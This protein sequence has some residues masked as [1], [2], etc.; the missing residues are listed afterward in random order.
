MIRVDSVVDL[1]PL[2]KLTTFVTRYPRYVNTITRSVANEQPTLLSELRVYPPVPAGSRYKRTFKLRDGYQVNFFTR[3]T[4]ILIETRNTSDRKR[5]LYVKG[6]RQTQKHR[7]TGWQK[8]DAII[9]TWLVRFRRRLLVGLNTGRRAL[10]G[11]R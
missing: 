4:E 1:R 10:T 9:K 8:D 2:D 3:G 6:R 11:I 5:H 7:Q